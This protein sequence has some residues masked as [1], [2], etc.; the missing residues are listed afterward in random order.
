[1][2]NNIK[3]NKVRTSLLL[4]A[5]S[6]IRHFLSLPTKI[7]SISVNILY[8]FYSNIEINIQN[9]FEFFLCERKNS[10]NLLIEKEEE[11]FLKKED[12][13]FT[14]IIETQFKI[15]KKLISDRKNKRFFDNI[16]KDETSSPIKKKLTTKKSNELSFSLSPKKKR[17][18]IQYLRNISRNF[19]KRRKHERKSISYYKS[20]MNK[21]III[22]NETKNK[23]IK[24]NNN[25]E[26]MKM[27]MVGSTK[28]I[29]LNILNSMHNEK[30]I[31]PV[32]KNSMVNDKDFF[33]IHANSST[34]YLKE[35]LRYK[36]KNLLLQNSSM[37]NC[38][39]PS[40]NRRTF[41]LKNIQIE[42]NKLKLKKK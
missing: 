36:C 25:N 17:S 2:S 21:S 19:I 11:S 28:N 20:N 35:N 1:M 41:T 24:N 39:G 31:S 14:P 33:L 30:S 15:K 9:P 32:K 29:K 7:N 18:S 12:N 23:G 40:F 34:V 3:A 38:I 4:K 6:E 26:L 22:S 42:K 10:T 27:H 16:N 13:D 5:Q 37:I 8:E